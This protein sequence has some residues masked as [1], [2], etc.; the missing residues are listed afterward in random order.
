VTG[1]SRRLS[2]KRRRY[3]IQYHADQDLE[4]L[5]TF[6]AATLEIESAEVHLQRKSNSNRLAARTWCSEHGVL[7]VTV[8]DTLLRAQ[9]GGWMDSLRESWL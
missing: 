9:M 5:R 4:A 2:S 1:G 7:S 8:N 6:W 3:S